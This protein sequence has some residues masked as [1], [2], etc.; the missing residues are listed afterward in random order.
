M[1]KNPSLTYFVENPAYG[2]FRHLECVVPHIRAGNFRRLQY[3]D[4][5][6]D[7]HPL[8]PTLVLTNC[9]TWVPLQMRLVRSKRPW[10]TLSKEQRTVIPRAV[11]EEALAAAVARIGGGMWLERAHVRKSVPVPP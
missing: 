1:P 5:A 2:A 4:Y 7:T 11:G 10:N 6:P 3:G 8:K 9:D